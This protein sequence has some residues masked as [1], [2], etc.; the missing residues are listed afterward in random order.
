[1]FVIVCASVSAYQCVC[2]SVCEFV[3]FCMCMSMRFS[4]YSLYYVS[5]SVSVCVVRLHVFVCF[6]VFV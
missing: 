4:V 6:C 5:F 2:V 3:S 1:M